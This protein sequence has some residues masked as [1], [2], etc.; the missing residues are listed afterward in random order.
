MQTHSSGA[1]QKQ[2]V[3]RALPIKTWR[4]FEITSV[5]AKCPLLV[6]VFQKTIRTCVNATPVRVVTEDMILKDTYSLK[7][8]GIIQVIGGAVHD[9]C[10]IWGDDVDTFNPYRFLKREG[11]T[12]EQKKAQ[13]SGL[14]PFGGPAEA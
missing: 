8:G 4:G 1:V 12:K 13:A 14:L 2:L 3:Q 9:S 11:L 5:K 6:S 10:K 7:K